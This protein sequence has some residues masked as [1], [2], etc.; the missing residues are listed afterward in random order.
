MT[1]R[2]Q[3]TASP[4]GCP[5]PQPRQPA[6]LMGRRPC[7]LTFDPRCLY[8]APEVGRGMNGLSAKLSPENGLGAEAPSQNPPDPHRS[9]A[10]RLR[11]SCLTTRP[12]RE[13]G[14]TGPSLRGGSPPHFRMA[15]DPGTNEYRD[16]PGHCLR[17]SRPALRGWAAGVR[18][19]VGCGSSSACGPGADACSRSP[20]RVAAGLPSPPPLSPR[21][22][23]QQDL[24]VPGPGEYCL[25]TRKA[26]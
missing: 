1:T 26:L 12:G 10:P 14:Q 8:H 15:T 4:I 5:R 20:S 13:P 2:C 21:G 6:A 16:R 18:M 9:A 24:I 7:P 11:S 23:G 3:W 17:H 22:R 25:L 19:S